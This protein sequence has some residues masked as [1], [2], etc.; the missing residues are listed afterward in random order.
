MGIQVCNLWKTFLEDPEL[1]EDRREYGIE[2]FAMAYNLSIADAAQIFK[3]F[4]R[5]E[6]GVPL[7][8]CLQP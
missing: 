2:D 5:H 8:D 3:A 1:F 7:N 6:K 4:R